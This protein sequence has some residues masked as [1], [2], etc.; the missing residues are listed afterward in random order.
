MRKAWLKLLVA[1]ALVAT[2]GM[3]AAGVTLAEKAGSKTCQA[4]TCGGQDCIL[5]KTDI[6]SSC[7]F[8]GNCQ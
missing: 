1:V 3:V 7:N 4:S 6:A 8:H 5:C 2:L